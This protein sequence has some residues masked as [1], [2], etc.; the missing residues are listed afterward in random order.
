VEV[1]ESSDRCGGARYPGHGGGRWALGQK[2]SVGCI[3]E[4]P[5]GGAVQKYQG[6]KDSDDV[7]RWR[8]NQEEDN[9]DLKKKS[10]P[11][12]SR[13]FLTFSFYFSLF[14]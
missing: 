13:F 11:A 4:E 3:F 1:G 5:R 10:V 7:V 8:E 9:D 2:M 14:L 12:C 6:K